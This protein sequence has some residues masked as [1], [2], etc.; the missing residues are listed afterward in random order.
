MPSL[1]P[2]NES[3]RITEVSG[4]ELLSLWKPFKSC[5]GRCSYCT[6]MLLYSCLTQQQIILHYI[7]LPFAVRP[8]SVLEYCEPAVPAGEFFKVTKI[9]QGLS[10][11]FRNRVLFGRIIT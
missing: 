8:K 1:K 9:F 11:A 3:S 10:T 7:N 5:I 2:S 4:A 6:V